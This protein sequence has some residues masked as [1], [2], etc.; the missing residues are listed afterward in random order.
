MS[1]NKKVTRYAQNIIILMALIVLFYG[2]VLDNN[3][4]LKRREIYGEISQKHKTLD[5]LNAQ[6]KILQ[7]S[8]HLLQYDSATLIRIAR[9]KIGMSRPNE[10]VFRLIPIDSNTPK[11]Y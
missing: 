5:S 8:I 3:G 1:T 4:Y 7:D 6:I 2:I 10:K 9:A 11:A